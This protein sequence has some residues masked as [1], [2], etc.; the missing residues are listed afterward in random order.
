VTY[1]EFIISPMSGLIRCDHCGKTLRW[2][3]QIRVY[4]NPV[5]G[6]IV[7]VEHVAHTP[8]KGSVAVQ[9]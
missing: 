2:P 9:A 8:R 1:S 3:E 4:T 7:R 6:R 5:E